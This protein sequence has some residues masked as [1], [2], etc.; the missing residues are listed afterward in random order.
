MEEDKQN[1]NS[2]VEKEM[3]DDGHR[4]LII[5]VIKDRTMPMDSE[6]SRTAD[7]SLATKMSS[8]TAPLNL[9]D[10]PRHCYIPPYLLGVFIWSVVIC[11]GKGVRITW[12]GKIVIYGVHTHTWNRTRRMQVDTVSSHSTFRRERVLT[13]NSLNISE[14]PYTCRCA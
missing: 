2:D 8:R 1:E 6:A 14:C 13:P 4:P 11:Y 10:D 3:D 9:I 5:R 12:F 7:F